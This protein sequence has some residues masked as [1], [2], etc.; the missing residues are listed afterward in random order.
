MT[1]LF[2]ESD[3]CWPWDNGCTVLGVCCVLV[4]EYFWHYVTVLIA[5]Y[6]KVEVDEQDTQSKDIAVTEMYVIVLERFNIALR[7][8]SI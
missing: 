1:D 8:A 3:T 2:G 5:R 7:K 6:L 4:L